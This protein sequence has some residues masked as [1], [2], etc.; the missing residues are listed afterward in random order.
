MATLSKAQNRAS[1]AIESSSVAEPYLMP[2]RLPGSTCGAL[3]MDSM[4]PATTI[5]ASPARIAWSARAI[6]SRPDRQTLF[7]VTDGTVMGMPPLTAAWR[8]VIWP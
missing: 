7:T 2:A 8:A 1:W 5:S 6:A 3:V 4:P